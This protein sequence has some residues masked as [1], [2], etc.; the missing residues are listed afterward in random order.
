MSEAE[1][2]RAELIGL[3][4]ASLGEYIASPI[5]PIMWCDNTIDCESI[6]KFVLLAYAVVG[7]DV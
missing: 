3:V 5:S 2:A 1:Q 7:G 4:A 6:V